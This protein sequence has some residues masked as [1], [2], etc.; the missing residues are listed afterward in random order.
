[1]NVGR[2]QSVHS[3][4]CEKLLVTLIVSYVRHAG[5]KAAHLI[6]LW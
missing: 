5:D 4:A 2:R 1:M 3:I 6:R